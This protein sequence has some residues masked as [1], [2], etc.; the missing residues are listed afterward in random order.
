MAILLKKGIDIFEFPVFPIETCR[1]KKQLEFLNAQ[2]LTRMN[3]LAHFFDKNE[4]FKLFLFFL[5]F[6]LYFIV[7]LLFAF[8]SI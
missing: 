7:L 4:K 8:C 6:P 3:D 1:K 2:N 5:L